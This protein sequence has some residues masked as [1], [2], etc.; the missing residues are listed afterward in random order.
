[1]EAENVVMNQ[2]VKQ[3]HKE[4]LINV[5]HMEVERDVMNRI[6]NQVHEEIPINVKDMEG[7]TD[8]RIVK[9]GPIQ[10]VDV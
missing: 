7:E 9:I 5:S 4:K 8:V 2:I 10:D 3:A 6:V 1:M